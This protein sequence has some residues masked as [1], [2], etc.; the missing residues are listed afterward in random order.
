M[1]EPKKKGKNIKGDLE[2]KKRKALENLTK[3]R[4]TRL[5]N[6][7]KMKEQPKEDEYEIDSSDS[8]SDTDDEDFDFVLSKTPKKKDDKK[9]KQPDKERTPKKKDH[10]HKEDNK[11]REDVD[12]LKTLTAQLIELQKKKAKKKPKPASNKIIV[13]PQQGGTTVVKPTSNDS[14]MD[15]LRRSLGM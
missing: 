7:R 3:A 4:A 8:E 6:L 13:L 9:D 10:R 12:Q 1:T 15:A 2:A 5:E 14:V 11:L